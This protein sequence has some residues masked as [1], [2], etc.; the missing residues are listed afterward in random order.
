MFLSLK[1][2]E[3]E[4]HLASLPR[5]SWTSALPLRDR[6]SNQYKCA[7]D[8]CH[9]SGYL[10]M[11]RLMRG[12]RSNLT[13][14][15]IIGAQLIR[16]ILLIGVS[17]A[18]LTIGLPATSNAAHPSLAVYTDGLAPGWSDWSWSTQI[19]WEDTSN[20]QS[21][22]D[23]IA[24]TF[25]NPWDGLSVHSNVPVNTTPYDQLQF[26]I[27]GGTSGG[28]QLWVFLEDNNN[29]LSTPVDISPYVQD[30][31]IA[32]NAWSQV[33]IPLS[34]L[35]A[36]G[37]AVDRLNFFNNTD[38]T[39]PTMYLD[40]ISFF[41]DGQA[42]PPPATASV[43]VTV[44]A[45]SHMHPI[46]PYIYGVAFGG[47]SL[48]SNNLTLDRWGGNTTSRYNWRLGSAVNT[49]ND[50]YFENTNQ[51]NTC[52]TPGC[53]VDQMVK[54]DR[55]AKAASLITV[56]TLGWVAKDTI[57]DTCGFSVKK[58]GGQQE[59]DPYRPNCGNGVTPSGQDITDNDPTDTSV[60]STPADIKEWIRHLVAKWGTAAKGGVKFF[61]MDNEPELW[62]AT[63][64]DV[65]PNP[66]TY[67]GLYNEFE[68]YASAVKSVDSSAMIDGPI[69]WGWSAYFD[70]SY[71]Y[72]NHT[73]SDQQAHGGLAILPWFLKA[74][75]AHDV[76]THH[77]TLN[78]L[79][80]HFYPQGNGVFS[81]ANDPT[82]DALRLRETRGLW[83]PTY[84]DES[85]IN[86][87]IDLIPRMDSWI[88]QYYPGTKLGI[89]EWNFGN[90]NS[91]NGALAIA[92]AL[93]IYGQEGVYLASYW[94]APP[95]GSP[96]AAAFDM[97]RDYDGHDS[98][99][100]NTSVKTT[101]SNPGSMMAFGSL[102]TI[103][104][105]LLLML[106]NQEPDKQEDVHLSLTHFAAGSMA[107][108]YTLGPSS[109]SVGHSAP[110]SAAPKMTVHVKPYTIE[111]LV[112]P[113]K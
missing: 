95:A 74:V 71:D 104:G 5:F 54:G 20:P 101:S 112:F 65:A 31:N 11:S 26:W 12:V 93:G 80:I 86:S 57:L 98:V 52:T 37:T 2:A 36:S 17:A 42:P 68:T 4:R 102:R 107:Q 94:T 61:A 15:Q 58:Y 59:T 6:K 3:R 22:T 89:S 73:E 43:N 27:N 40:N 19:N 106:V 62:Y 69:P 83:D 48:K 13:L 60:P 47:S 14:D 76:E 29:E 16:R 18:T 1:V 90:A 72:L 91:M 10:M 9:C 23:D 81:G 35:G 77:R 105:H 87:N 30:G 21:G 7:K 53:A 84:T 110:I 25:D 8:Y 49:A 28:Q 103:D 33:D 32:S 92:D 64:R 82:T 100:G 113:R 46:S 97:Y 39:Q 44:D 55:A 88:K 51:G 41:D 34:V 63:H 24:F 70:S 50:W 79:D 111:L 67:D 96:G 38:S 45:S 109:S 75:H 99:F 66:L 85:W 108:V 56:P 78:V